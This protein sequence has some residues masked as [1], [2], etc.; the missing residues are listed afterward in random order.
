ML[1]SLYYNEENMEV[2]MNKS[3]NN[4][5]IELM[6]KLNKQYICYYTKKQVKSKYHI[7]MCDMYE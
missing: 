2:K 3:V 4:N 5:V 7:Y 6:H 1:Y